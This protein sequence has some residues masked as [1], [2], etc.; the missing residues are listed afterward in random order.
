M[1]NVNKQQ[2]KE[3]D[4]L[5]FTT[6]GSVDDGKSTLIGRILFDSKGVY[7]D[8]LEA[9][10]NITVGVEGV[11]LAALTDGL[12]AEREQGITIDVAYRYF[13]T[14]KRKFIIADTPGHEQYTRNMV[15]GASTANAAIVLIDA[16]K[17]VRIQSRRHATIAQLLG[18]PYVIVAINKMD[19]VD[20]SEEIYNEIYEEF[21]LFCQE[22]GIQ[23]VS[24]VP[25]SAL[26]GDMVVN[27]G[28]NMPWYQGATL[29]GTLETLPVI[30]DVH[31]HDFRFPIQLVSRPQTPELHDFRGYM[32]RIEAGIV[33]VGD[34]VTLQP[35]GKTTRIKEIV[36]FDGNL[37][38]AHAPQ[39]VTLTLEDEFDLSR[40]DMIVSGSRIPAVEKTFQAD[41]CWMSE[42]PMKLRGKYL[43]K[44]TSNSVKG[45]VNALDYRIDINSQEKVAG[46]DTLHCN[47]IGRVS[48]KSQ[49]PLIFDDYSEIRDTGAFILIDEASNNTVAAGMIQRA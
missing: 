19:L 6:A 44:H 15:T 41:L 13:A 7:E 11:D 8:Q 22:L 32:G 12:D 3:I 47:E 27:R 31:R 25:V 4:L 43:I 33:R 36:T 45:L 38:E 29:L 37:Q 48:I 1:S 24:F 21:S 2:N 42:T 35:S 17:G 10:N 30:D 14:A 16:R 20:Y 39:S 34:E 23:H 9:V 26:E 40:G 5:R 49:Q 18:I 46:V 28:D